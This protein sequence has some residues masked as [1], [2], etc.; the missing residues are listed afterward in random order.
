MNCSPRRICADLFSLK[1][2]GSKCFDDFCRGEFCFVEDL[3][4]PE[5]HNPPSL[6]LA[7]LVDLAVAVNVPLGFHSPVLLVRLR[8]TVTGGAPMPEAAIHEHCESSAREDQVRFSSNAVIV[9]PVA[10]DTGACECAAQREFSRSVFAGNG[11]HDPGAFGI[12]C[13]EFRSSRTTDGLWLVD[14]CREEV[15]ADMITKCAR[16]Q[17]E[18]PHFRRAAS[19]WSANLQRRKHREMIGTAR[20]PER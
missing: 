17:R 13:H 3:M 14:L 1:F 10:T 16:Q 20:L 15:F 19:G 11:S 4:F 2:R 8:L 18:A 5:T 7:K 12:R 6:R 9:Q